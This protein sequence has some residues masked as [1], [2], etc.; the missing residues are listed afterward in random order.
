MCDGVNAMW[1]LNVC[2]KFIMIL[3]FPIEIRYVQSKIKT[4]TSIFQVEMWF[5]H[6]DVQSKQVHMKDKL[7]KTITDDH[8]L[9]YIET[10]PC[11]AYV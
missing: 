7:H 6:K 2:E 9:Q 10:L 1:S 4:V 11:S 3:Q 8:I 5:F